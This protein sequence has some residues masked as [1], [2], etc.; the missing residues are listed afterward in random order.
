MRRAE[1]AVVCRN[2]TEAALGLYRQISGMNL[3]SQSL[4]MLAI[5]CSEWHNCAGHPGKLVT[6]L[7]WDHREVP[8]EFATVKD[9]N[10]LGTLRERDFPCFQQVRRVISK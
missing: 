10:R 6:Q 7:C 9:S 3:G 1:V 8:P 2:R 5:H 4:D